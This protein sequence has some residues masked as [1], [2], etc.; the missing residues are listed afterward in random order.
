MI[1]LT[2]ADSEGWSRFETFDTE[3]ECDEFVEEELRGDGD[4]WYNPAPYKI[5]G[6]D[7][8]RVTYDNFRYC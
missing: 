4:D 5:I 1:T 3:K 6:D 7:H 8:K 2:Y